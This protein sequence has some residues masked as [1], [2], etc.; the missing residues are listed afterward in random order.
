MIYLIKC[1]ESTICKIGFSDD[2]KF[3]VAQI[4]YKHNKPVE[5]KYLYYGDISEERKVHK[6]FSEFR[7]PYNKER[8]WFEFTTSIQEHFAS[9]VNELEQQ[10]KAIQNMY[11]YPYVANPYFIQRGEYF[12][13]MLNEYTLLDM[14]YKGGD[15]FEVPPGPGYNSKYILKGLIADQVIIPHYKK[16]YW[17][18]NPN[19]KYI[20]KYFDQVTA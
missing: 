20:A 8:E 13:Q 16:D 10:N 6:M 15:D 9:K 3:R 19:S 18:I 17:R 14:L 2:I 11:N 7:V 1:I 4:G 12:K 5:L